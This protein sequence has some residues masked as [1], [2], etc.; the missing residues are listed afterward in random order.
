[1][2][3]KWDRL[4]SLRTVLLSLAGFGFLCVAAFVGLGLWAGFLAVGLSCLALEFLSNGE[5]AGGLRR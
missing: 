2:G 5:H 3:L 4:T 1:M